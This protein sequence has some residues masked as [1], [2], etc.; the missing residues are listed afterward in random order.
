MLPSP[1]K[2]ASLSTGDPTGPI[3]FLG[4]TCPQQSLPWTSGSAAGA[5]PF[6][7]LTALK[8]ETPGDGTVGQEGEE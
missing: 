5:L 3:P 1:P 7:E 2:Q 6:C 8:E 4:L